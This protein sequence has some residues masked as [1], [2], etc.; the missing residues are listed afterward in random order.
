MLEARALHEAALAG[1]AIVNAGGPIPER[2]R[3]ISL[4][5]PGGDSP[6]RMVLYEPARPRGLC[7][8]FHGGGFIICTPE[9]HDKIARSIAVGAQCIVASVDYRRAPEHPF[10][11]AYD[12]AL[13]AAKWLSDMLP[14]LAPGGSLILAGDSSG[15]NLAAGAALALAREGRPVAGAVLLY[16]WLDLG[17]DSESRRRL[18][19]DDI[20]I[21]DEFMDYCTQCYL[22]AGEI[23]DPR[24]SPLFADL[25]AFPP[26]VVICGTLDPLLSDSERFVQRLREN[27]RSVEWRPFE[28]MP[29]G[30]ISMCNSLDDGQTALK[31]AVSSTARLMEESS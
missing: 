31:L 21:D 17:R 27:G 29:H 18:G 6:I 11:A 14:S 30:F 15:G 13:E 16:P 5:R 2:R 26:S 22:P 24:A 28:G 19:P 3:E 25:S 1:A 10:P 12:D 8:F 9:T 23:T 20:I 7:V 4:P